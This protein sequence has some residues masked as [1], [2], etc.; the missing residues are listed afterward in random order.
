V[1]VNVIGWH[2]GNSERK[3][4]L[5]GQKEA[6]AFGLYDMHGNVGEWCQD[7]YHDSY[8]GAPM[9]GSGWESGGEQESRVLRGGAWFLKVDY[10]RSAAR[11]RA[12]PTIR[13]AMLGFRVVALA[14]SQ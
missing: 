9:D 4:H 14:Q 6:N 10:L 2:G 11:A 5:V 7:W 8:N 13:N 12:M 1:P 3:T